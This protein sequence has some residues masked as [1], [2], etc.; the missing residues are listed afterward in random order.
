MDVPDPNDQEV[1]QFAATATLE[2]SSDDVNA[3]T[4]GTADETNP[5]DTVEGNWS[6]RW[7]G[8]TDPTIAGDAPDKWK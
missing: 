2:G 6:S 3:A 5:R 8:G 1:M 4:W 7:K